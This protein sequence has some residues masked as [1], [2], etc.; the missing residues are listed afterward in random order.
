[1]DPILLGKGKRPVYLRPEFGNRHGLVAG[2]TGTGKTV[3]LLVLA[4]G[5]S[6]LGVPVFMADVKGDVAGL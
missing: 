5:F 4:E 1:M 3:S 6:R 2:A